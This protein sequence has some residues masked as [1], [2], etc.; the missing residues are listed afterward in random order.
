MFF[1]LSGMGGQGK[2]ATAPTLLPQP[3]E[4]TLRGYLFPDPVSKECDWL[5]MGLRS[6]GQHVL[7]RTFLQGTPKV[8]PPLAEG[9]AISPTHNWLAHQVPV[10]TWCSGQLPCPR[11][12]SL[13]M[14]VAA[15]QPALHISPSIARVPRSSLSRYPCPNAASRPGAG[16]LAGFGFQRGQA[17]RGSPRKGTLPLPGIPLKVGQKDGCG[18]G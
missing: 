14:A 1:R 4:T 10:L 9:A 16:A 15:R 13:R 17:C 7:P 8:S 2:A 3:R 18:P 5:P 12:W 6:P 11:L